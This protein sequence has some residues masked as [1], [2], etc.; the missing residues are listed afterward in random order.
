MRAV[1]YS[2]SLLDTYGKYDIF[3]CHYL[4]VNNEKHSLS[5]QGLSGPHNHVVCM[6]LSHSLIEKRRKHLKDI[7]MEILLSQKQTLILDINITL[8]LPLFPH[9]KTRIITHNKGSKKYITDIV[10]VFQHHLKHAPRH[11]L[12][13]SSMQ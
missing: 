4:L 7:E 3:S 6:I 2:Q 10:N 5:L 13:Q 1:N 8:L 11:I 12:T 9:S